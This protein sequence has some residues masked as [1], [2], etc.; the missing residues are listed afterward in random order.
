MVQVTAAAI[1]K[2]GR[3]LIAKRKP[4]IHLANKWELP[5][6]K[7]KPD[8]TMV[9]SLKRVLADEFGIEVEIDNFICA[10]TYNYSF[11]VIELYAYKVNLL[12][13]EFLL[14]EHDEIRCVLPLELLQYDFIE[15]VVPICKRLMEEQ[16]EGNG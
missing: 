9:Q 13:G 14:R 3:I 1:F 5:G 2:D 12:S 11:G 8:E 10:S 4:G 6:G 15:A 7:L 16:K